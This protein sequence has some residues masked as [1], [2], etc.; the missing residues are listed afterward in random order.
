MAKFAVI[1]DMDGVLINSRQN[2]LDSL[3]AVFRKHGVEVAEDEMKKFLGISLRETVNE[4]TNVFGVDLIPEEVSKEAG[5]IELENLDDAKPDPFLMKL[6][7]KLQEHNIRMG[8]GTNSFRERAENILR[9]FNL[10]NHFVSIVTP[11]DVTGSKVEILL[12]VA[13]ELG[14]HPHHCIYIDDTPE[15]VLAAKSCGMKAIGYLH[16]AEIVKILKTL[17]NNYWFW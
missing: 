8:I 6:L 17:I 1:F 10:M 16:P 15:G 12:A 3:D 9:H 11:E 5:K 4:I 2:I 14:A 13:K 7:D